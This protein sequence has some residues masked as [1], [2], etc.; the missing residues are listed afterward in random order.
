MRCS[1]IS[2]HILPMSSFEFIANGNGAGQGKILDDPSP[3]RPLFNEV[4]LVLIRKTREK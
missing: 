2:L 4:V 1:A 3:Y